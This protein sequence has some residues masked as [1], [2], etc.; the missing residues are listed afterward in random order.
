MG[1]F[2]NVYSV[3]TTIFIIFFL[4]PWMWFLVANWLRKAFGTGGGITKFLNTFCLV[5]RWGAASVYPS[6][7]HDLYPSTK[8]IDFKE[9]IKG[10][11]ENRPDVG[12]KNL[13]GG[14]MFSGCCDF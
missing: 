6:M 11:D 2:A 5:N 4:I 7:L 3:F 12:Y 13:N 8:W 10:L 1:T 9:H 14:E